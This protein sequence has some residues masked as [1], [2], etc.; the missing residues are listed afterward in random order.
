MAKSSG[1]RPLTPKQNTFVHEYLKDL[2]ATQSAIRAGYS[3]KTAEAIG[4][5][6]LQKPLIQEAIRQALEDREKATG[7]TTQRVLRELGA[8]AFADAT[9]V[10]GVEMKP[11]LKEERFYKGNRRIKPSE[12]YALPYEE[13]EKIRIE[14]VMEDRQTVV[15]QNMSELSPDQK[16]S[17]ASIKQGKNGIE[18]TFH[19][20]EK[21][22][23]MI[24]RHLGMF[25]DKV[26]HS[27]TVRTE[28]VD[29]SPLSTE[30]LRKLANLDE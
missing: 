13:Q 18:V 7:I 25:N 8:I 17:I 12:F 10:V 19:N 11:F 29:V 21:A 24:A 27:G 28:N 5:E 3:K 15:I 14:E 30:E 1:N 22:L 2:N 26:E 16:K 9:D 6:N 20:K 23:E 4:K